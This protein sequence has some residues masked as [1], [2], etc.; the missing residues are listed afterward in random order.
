MLFRVQ[1]SQGDKPT[2][3]PAWGFSSWLCRAGPEG[4]KAACCC[5]KS[6]GCTAQLRGWRRISHQWL[7]HPHWDTIPSWDT[8]TT[9]PGTLPVPVG[10]LQRAR[11]CQNGFKPEP[12]PGFLQTFKPSKSCEHLSWLE[13][14]KTATS[15][16]EM[17]AMAAFDGSK[18]RGHKHPAWPGGSLRFPFPSSWTPT[19][20]IHAV[21]STALQSHTAKPTQRLPSQDKLHPSCSCKS[22]PACHSQC[23]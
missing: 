14:K 13:Q 9:P 7:G 10:A 22:K 23:S 4:S 16:T 15:L 21:P 5:G 1:K 18:Q 2:W 20:A 6:S 8:H 12:A 3:I 11:S 19:I 17:T